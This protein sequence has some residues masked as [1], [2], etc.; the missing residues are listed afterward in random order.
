MVYQ[1][2]LPVEEFGVVGEHPI[3]IEHSG[4]YHF[5]PYDYD[6]HRGEILTGVKDPLEKLGSG[7]KNPRGKSMDVSGDT[8]HPNM[9]KRSGTRSA[10][11]PTLNVSTKAYMSPT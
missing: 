7:L 10:L 11:H 9:K 4:A 2:P 3:M 6:K 8:P 5:V 1:D